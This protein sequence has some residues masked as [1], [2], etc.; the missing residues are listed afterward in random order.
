MR[1]QFVDYILPTL[2]EPQEVWLQAQ[3]VAGRVRY[4][5]VYLGAG[6]RA[7]AQEHRGGT[8]GWTYPVGQQE[9]RRTGYLLYQKS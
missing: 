3:R 1:E 9:K 2:R 5:A 7:V 6:G 4:M 8:V